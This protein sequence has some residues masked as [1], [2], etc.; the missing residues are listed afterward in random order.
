MRRFFTRYVAVLMIAGFSVLPA[1]AAPQRDHSSPGLFERIVKII[2]HVLPLDDVK[3]D[4]P[5]P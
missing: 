2:R 4:L 1:S 5:K 3:V